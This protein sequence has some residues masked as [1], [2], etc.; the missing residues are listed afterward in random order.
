CRVCGR[1]ACCECIKHVKGLTFPERTLKEDGTK[2]MH[3]NATFL[4]C[5]KRPEHCFKDFSPVT[6]FCKEELDAEVSAMQQFLSEYVGAEVALEHEPSI[7]YNAEW[8]VD[9][10][11]PDSV[12]RSTNNCSE[13]TGSSQDTALDTPTLSLLHVPAP[14]PHPGSIPG[15]VT[16]RYGDPL[17]P[18]E[19]PPAPY[20]I[21]DG[22]I[23]D[24]HF[25]LIWARGQPLVVTELLQNFT[26]RWD[27]KHFI[28]HYGEE[29]C[30]IL[31]CHTNEN[32]NIDVGRF[33][34][35]FG[36]QHERGDKCWKLKVC[37]LLSL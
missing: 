9:A 37:V 15:A 21:F 3:T 5:V 22:E 18:A 6:R 13:R 36:K 17:D 34:G 24:E 2:K 23:S 26:I 27:P 31:E 4:S 33:F 29:H 25:R 32:K 30:L 14:P 28:D 10:L 16:G 11:L 35:Q 12:T 19:I 20:Y 1:E 7:I 8:S